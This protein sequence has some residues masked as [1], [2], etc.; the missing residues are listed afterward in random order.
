MC[1]FR[2][3]KNLIVC[4]RQGSRVPDSVATAINHD[5]SDGGLWLSDLH[6]EKRPTTTNMEQY[7]RHLLPE[8]MFPGRNE[9]K[10]E[11]DFVYFSR[12]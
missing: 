5:Q 9:T 7:M 8:G 3:D 1:C 2:E 4:W 11:I 12:P 10:S 6:N